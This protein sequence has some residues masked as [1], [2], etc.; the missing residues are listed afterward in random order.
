[1]QRVPLPGA[2]PWNFREKWSARRA[3]KKRMG[4][5]PGVPIGEGLVSAEDSA[6]I[7]EQLGFIPNN[8][9]AVASRADNGEPAV[10]K[11]YPLA[12]SLKSARAGNFER[13]PFPTMY[14]LSSPE[15]KTCVSHLERRGLVA[16]WEKRLQGNQA[17]IDEMKMAHKEYAN[18]RWEML[19]A[20]DQKMVLKKGWDGALG[21]SVGVAGITQPAA[22]KC[23]HAHFAH[24]LATGNNLVGKWVQE[25]LDAE[26][27]KS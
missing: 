20:A 26:L 12:V 8:V 5:I 3:Y 9:V 14:W 11:L 23:L 18:E 21:Q 1:M 4:Q 15:F 13:Q 25:A 24:F 19:M 17:Y 6:I 27:G 10:L 16:Q 2:G 22:I 7:E